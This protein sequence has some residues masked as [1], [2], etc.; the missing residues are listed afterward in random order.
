LAQWEPLTLA[1]PPSASLSALPPVSEAVSAPPLLPL[2]AAEESD[3]DP[4]TDV[5]T[6]QSLYR[7]YDGAKKRPSGQIDAITTDY[8]G[9]MSAVDPE[10]ATR[11]G[12]HSG[13]ARATSYDKK[14]ELKRDAFYERLLLRLDKIPAGS[15]GFDDRVDHYLLASDLR[16]QGSLPTLE[17]VLNSPLTT[18]SMHFLYRFAPKRKRYETA[19][20]RFE[21]YPKILRQ[22]RRQIESAS[23]FER[24]TA[25]ADLPGARLICEDFAKRLAKGLPEQKER[26]ERAAAAASRELDRFEEFLADLPLD[27]TGW[28]MGRKALDEVL[29]EHLVGADTDELLRR[30]SRETQATL[31]ELRATAAELFPGMS[32][33]RAIKKIV[34][35]PA[36][37]EILD[38][39]RAA[40]ER[41]K[42]HI[43]EAG[44]ATPPYAK[45]QVHPTPEHERVAI[46]FAAYEGPLALDG[47]KTGHLFATL[48]PRS[49]GPSE[50]EDWLQANAVYEVIDLNSVHEAF[51]GHHVQLSRSKQ[52]PNPLRRIVWDIFF[53]EGW[54]HY[55]EGVMADTGFMGPSGRLVMLFERRWQLARARVTLGLHA[56]GWS[57]ESATRYIQ[58]TLGLPR[59]DAESS[60]TRYA[61]LDP[62][63]SLAY[64]MGRLEILGVR[65]RTRRRLGDRF[66]LKE[67][68][69][70]LL[71][72]GAI[73]IALVERLL[74]RDWK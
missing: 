3:A 55:I 19:L 26:V 73:P 5:D 36:P 64:S 1:E 38:A 23:R 37:S 40:T 49:A 29:S 9:G 61:V 69:D 42:K 43:A 46:P 14:T 54:A 13:D 18:I 67:F 4:G 56:Q 57:A 28:R 50:L 52:S 33:Q 24:S 53:G 65:E 6:L 15:L 21:Q 66:S 72:Y 22:G 68:H 45:L 11:L 35:H 71:T 41:A 63:E 10:S 25:R 51:P 7:T 59:A 60:V 39:Y 2:G 16:S 12:L 58:K 27:R 48:P 17:A 31:A 30:I 32:W 20:S 74:E 8:L 62:M 70:R 34:R 47:T 44:V